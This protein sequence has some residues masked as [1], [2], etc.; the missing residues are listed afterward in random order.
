MKSLPGIIVGLA[1]GAAVGLLLAPQSGKKTRKRI[2]SESDSFFKDLQD[3]LQ[4]GLENIK[5]Q[6]N[7]YVDTA[8]SKTEDA[9]KQVKRKANY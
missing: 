5:S 1:V 4:A 9:V 8:S 3:Q 7:N 6:Y 2:T